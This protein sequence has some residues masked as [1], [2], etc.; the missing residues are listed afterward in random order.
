MFVYFHHAYYLVF[1]LFEDYLNVLEKCGLD[2][3]RL[4]SAD[5]F[6]GICLDD[7]DVV[8]D[9]VVAIYIYYTPFLVGAP[10]LRRALATRLRLV[11]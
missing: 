9:S 5:L 6:L 8:C 11:E 10:A 7:I 4:S 2:T 3:E 1:D